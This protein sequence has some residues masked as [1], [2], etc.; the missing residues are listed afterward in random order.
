MDVKRFELAAAQASGIVKALAHPVRL[1]IVCA[2]V[3]S[4][5][6][7]NGLA[8]VTGVSASTVSRHLTLLRKDRVV[9]A[10]RE[11]Q[12]LV[13]SLRDD[14]V[15]KFVTILAEIF[16]APATSQKPRRKAQ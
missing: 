15:G 4:D 6:C 1:R 2:L 8:D 13:Y 12:S 7:V 11:R 10:R 14:K 5:V 16:C 3:G 9:K